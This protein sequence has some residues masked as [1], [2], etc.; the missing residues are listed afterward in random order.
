MENTG[1]I[2]SFDIHSSK[3]PLI[4]KSAERLGI[5][6]ITAREND[7][8]FPA[9]EL[10][11]KADTVICDV[12][13]SGFG[14]IAKKPEIRYKPLSD[15]ASLPDLQFEILAKSSMYCEPGGKIMYSTCTLNPNENERVSER[16]LSS[17][18][19]FARISGNAGTTVFPDAFH[20]GFYYDIFIRKD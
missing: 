8:R 13:C 17:A 14:V 5:T 1:A 11:G 9:A 15:L 6:N 20:D 3:L 2:Y 4:T 16:F 19:Q 10:V 18:P 7:A 12:P